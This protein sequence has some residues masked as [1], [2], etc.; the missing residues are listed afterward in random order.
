MLQHPDQREV[1]IP[2]SPWRT[3]RM[4]TEQNKKEGNTKRRENERLE[5]G[6]RKVPRPRREESK[7][8]T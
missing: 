3:E 6:V 5:E 7:E 4:T 1:V 8:P 2:T